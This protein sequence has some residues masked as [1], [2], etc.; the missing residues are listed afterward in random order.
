MK[1][2]PA[3]D[4]DAHYLAIGE[5][6][7]SSTGKIGLRHQWSYDAHAVFELAIARDEL[8]RILKGERKRPIDGRSVTARS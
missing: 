2:R 1:V 8:S 6:T 7:A 3:P 4:V 5:R